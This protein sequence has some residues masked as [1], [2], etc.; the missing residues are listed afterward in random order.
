MPGLKALLDQKTILAESYII[1]ARRH[2]HSIPEL[3]MQEQKTSAFIR[4]ELIKMGY[5][6]VCGIANTGITA[7]LKFS[8]PGPCLMV[9]ADMD[10]LPMEE[11]TGLPFASTH[12]GR[13]HACGHDGHVAMVLGA[14]RVMSELAASNEGETLRGSIRF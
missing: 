6:P 7:D 9:R 14:A 8:G 4:G 13:M 10:A 11:Q 5:T 2:L 3:G 1:E 12:P